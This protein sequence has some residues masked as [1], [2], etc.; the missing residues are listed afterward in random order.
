[1]KHRLFL[2]AA[3]FS[4]SLLFSQNPKGYEEGS[5]LLTSGETIKGWIKFKSGEEIKNR[6]TI[7]LNEQEKR[8]YK[9]SDIVSFETPDA[10]FISYEIAKEGVFLRVLAD[11]AIQL[12]ELQ[13]AFSQGSSDSYKYEMYIRRQGEKDLV[14]IKQ[15][16]WKK[17]IVEYIADNSAILQQL[18]KG[19]IKQDELPVLIQQY[20]N[21]KD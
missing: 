16:S 2:L 9:H 13:Y 7:I 14:A 11:G 4:T 12:Y 1:M 17:Q 6:L 15:G 19:K 21:D 10:S 18:E 8:T 20:N 5:V 3:L